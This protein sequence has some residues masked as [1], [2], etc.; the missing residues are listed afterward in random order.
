MTVDFNI[1]IYIEREKITKS[2][3]CFL[4]YLR[5]GVCVVGLC[6]VRF[7]SVLKFIGMA[8]WLSSS[9]DAKPL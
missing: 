7:D 4:I 2:Y 6:I 5:V 9:R 1:Y 8:Y 3:F